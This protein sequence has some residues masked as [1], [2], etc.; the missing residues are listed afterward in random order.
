MPPTS[1]SKSSLKGA[2]R[3]RP[4]SPVS[5]Y[6]SG[7]GLGMKTPKPPRPLVS[8]EKRP[9]RETKAKSHTRS[10]SA[11]T[12]TSALSES[13]ANNTPPSP[14]SVK[15]KKSTTSFGFS[16]WKKRAHSSSTTSLP[17]SPMTPTSP[18]ADTTPTRNI[19]SFP[20]ETSISRV[21]SGTEV[22]S[23]ARQLDKATRTFGERVPVEY[24][25]RHDHEHILPTTITALPSPISSTSP[26]ADT[27]PTQTRARQ[28]D[29][30]ARTFGERL[31]MDYSLNGQRHD[32]EH[33]LPHI[34]TALPLDEPTDPILPADDLRY[35]QF[36]TS[37]DIT[38]SNT[39]VP[40]SPTGS[41]R[42]SSSVFPNEDDRDLNQTR[43]QSSSSTQ[44]DLSPIIFTSALPDPI[45]PPRP[46][47]E[48]VAS[49]PYVRYVPRPK[50]GPLSSLPSPSSIGLN[51]T[52]AVDNGAIKIRSPKRPST[53]SSSI[54]HSPITRRPSRLLPLRPK[55]SHEE[56]TPWEGESNPHPRPDSPFQDSSIPI[57]TWVSTTWSSPKKGCI[58]RQ[59]GGQGWSGEWNRSDMQDVIAT[60]RQLK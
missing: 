59:E 7:A 50:P 58:I 6:G 11:S 3:R 12:T 60:L 13:S 26:S 32:H 55:S 47:K 2:P 39:I 17:S 18:M 33:I 15:S 40:S 51:K 10:T 37:I 24:L 36:P 43:S 25:Q 29:K 44:V 16:G 53:S 56:S 46:G 4:S 23:R 34:I 20:S 31:P 38:A 54:P 49:S 21:P 19:R 42:T 35:E 52:S 27:T 57:H 30:A 5:M 48:S 45:P 8:L 41:C 28:L 1:S 9:Q 14:S 22:E